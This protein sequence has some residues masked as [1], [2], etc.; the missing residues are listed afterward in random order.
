MPITGTSVPTYH[1][2]PAA[3]YGM[4][5]RSTITATVIAASSNTAPAASVA[6]IVTGYG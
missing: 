5:R 1:S 3:A 4:R 2:Q 6:G